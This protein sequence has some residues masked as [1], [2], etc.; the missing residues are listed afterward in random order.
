MKNN[1]FKR[2]MIAML[3]FTMVIMYGVVP[4]IPIVK[5]VD[6]IYNAKDTISD[7]D[8][9]ATNVIHT[10]E[11]TTASTTKASGGYWRVVMPAGFTS[12]ATG[13]DACAYGNTSWQS[14]ISG[15]NV[16][17]IYN[18]GTDFAATTTRIIITATNPTPVLAETS[19]I[20]T[21]TLEKYNA[22]AVLEERTYLKIAILDDVVVTAR[23]QSSLAFTVRGTTTPTATFNG[24]PCGV[25]TSTSTIDFGVLNTDQKYNACQELFVQSNASDGYIVTVEATD[26]LSNASG[27]TINSFNNSPDN[28]G[29][30]TPVAWAN[31][32]NILDAKHTYGHFGLTTNDADLPTSYVGGLYVGFND[33][34][35]VTIMSHN[36][37]TL[38]TTQNYGK[39]AVVYSLRVGTLQEAGDYETTLTYICTPTY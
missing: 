24:Q 2:S 14:S 26:E 18:G 35:P 28:T 39:A 16:D 31:P 8:R 4:S 19:A 29:S 25:Q 21:V 37:P 36:G 32:L 17:C 10:I 9:G 12:I 30:T 6:T 22:S 15:Q 23:V 5:A 38:G 3:I 33:T 34:D 13:T 27:D 20:Y 7:S 1:K 11:F